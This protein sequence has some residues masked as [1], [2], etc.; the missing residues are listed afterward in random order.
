MLFLKN[1]KF[2]D[3]I[4]FKILQFNLKLFFLLNSRFIALKSENMFS[5][6]TVF[7]IY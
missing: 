5:K 3:D 7:N 6:M 1:L 2:R 4:H